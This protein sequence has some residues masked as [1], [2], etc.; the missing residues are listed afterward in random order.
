MDEIRNISVK[1]SAALKSDRAKRVAINTVLAVHKK[2]IFDQGLDAG[3]AVIGTYST[4][5]IDIPPRKQARNTGKRHFAGG[6][7]EYKTAIGKNPGYVN[8]QNFGQ[9]MA[10]YG[11]IVNGQ[12]YGLGYNNSHNYDKSIWLQDKYKKEIFHHSQSEIDLL[13]NVLMF[14]LNK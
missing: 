8:L 2:R 4:E 9:M 3:G 6:Y 7:A 11:L 14:E 10:D 13:M 1:L 12:D 5:P